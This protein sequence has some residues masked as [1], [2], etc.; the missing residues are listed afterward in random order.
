MHYLGPSKFVV[1]E[2]K[3]FIH[4]PRESDVVA[5]NLDFWCIK[6]WKPYRGPPNNYK[7]ILGSTKF[8]VSLKKI[9][10]SHWSYTRN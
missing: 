6:K 9:F 7:Y 1:Y 4:I 3:N 2:E 5:A 8:L 10:I